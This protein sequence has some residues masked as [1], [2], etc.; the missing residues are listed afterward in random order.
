MALRDI[1]PALFSDDKGQL[2]TQDQID[3]HRKIAQAMIASGL[4]TSPVQHWS[5]GAA[6]LMNAIAGNMQMDRAGKEALALANNRGQA[7]GAAQRDLTGPPMGSYAASGP[8]GV[9]QPQPSTQPSATPASA[10]G[11]PQ[12]YR[13][14][15]ASIESA[16]SGNYSAVGPVNPKLGRP[17][18]RYGVMEGNLPEWSKAA[19]G[20]GITADQFLAD[21]KAQDAIFDNRFGGYVNQ[22]GPEGAAQAWFA[23]P[24]GVGKTDRKDVLGTDVGSYGHRFMAAINGQPQASAQA[25]NSVPQPAMGGGVSAHQQGQPSQQ[26]MNASYFPPAPSSDHPPTMG[27]YAAVGPR[28][29]ANMAQVYK[30]LYAPGV[31]DE[32]R[33]NFAPMIQ[34]QM[35]PYGFITSQDGTTLRTNA[36]A[37][38]VEPVYSSPKPQVIENQDGSRSIVNLNDPKA[39]A[40]YNARGG[41]QTL[42]NGHVTAQQ[43]FGI[44]DPK[45]MA[46]AYTKA[47]NDAVD[48][49]KPIP[50]FQ[51][52]LENYRKQGAINSESAYQSATGKDLG[53]RVGELIKGHDAYNE[54]LQAIHQMQAALPEIYTGA[55]GNL[56]LQARKTIQAASQAFGLS[57]EDV[58]DA[59]SGTEGFQ[60][61]AMKL[62]GAQAKALGGSRGTNFEL[63]QYI[64]N[65]PGVS[66]SHEG[67]G[68][69]LD[70]M[71]Q[72]AR[73]NIDKSDIAT[74]GA[75]QG[76]KPDEL[77]KRL[78]DYDS[79][80]QIIDKLTGVDLKT[81]KKVKPSAK[82]R[83]A[84]QLQ[85]GALSGTTPAG[86]D[87]AVWGVMTP[88]ERALWPN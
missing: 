40:G 52:W 87:P 12:A 60:K 85:S 32:D 71:E 65:N 37:G 41:G 24:G 86:V 74:H 27:S 39:I 10:P 80:S 33:R 4:D 26:P 81:G 76:L 14:A 11:N 5:Q 38:T 7:I 28:N 45:E 21:P 43:L 82:E 42:P 9:S 66:L 1:I 75:A 73:Q 34:A 30:D 3:A 83:R 61:W 6:R 17:L 84:L 68:T 2:A 72:Q 53:E 50:E 31:T 23:G 49:G 48:A 70:I 54:Q 8:S 44:K 57:N 13:D 77:M 64:K 58:N 29:G 59:I 56:S 69:L 47:R 19:L 18:G 20:H 35:S 16:G 15:V 78:D 79:K 51:G 25:T 46:V 22:F 62:A 63:D 67:N 88:E 55:G 36:R